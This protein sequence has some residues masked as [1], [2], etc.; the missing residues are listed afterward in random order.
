MVFTITQ[1]RNHDLDYRS[2]MIQS[3]NQF[4][5]TGGYIETRIQL[6]GSDAMSGFWP[7]AW[8]MGNLGRAGFGATNEGAYVTASCIRK[9]HAGKAGVWPFSYDTCDVGTRPNQ[10]NTDMR[11]PA[12]AVDLSYQPGQKMSACTCKGEDHPGPSHKVG[13]GSPEVDLIEAVVEG[14]GSASSR[15]GASQSMQLAPY[16]RQWRIDRSVCRIRDTGM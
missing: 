6:P 9:T 10:T 1:Q 12:A 13:R 3:W 11:S 4:C 16:D 14:H 7:G 5:F 8:T 15:G 2:A